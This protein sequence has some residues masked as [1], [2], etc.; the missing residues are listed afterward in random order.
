M[1]DFEQFRSPVEVWR[2]AIGDPSSL[3]DRLRGQTPMYEIERVAIAMLV[4][5]ELKRP[6]RRPSAQKLVSIW[7]FREMPASRRHLEGFFV[8]DDLGLRMQNAVDFYRHIM[9]ELR[10]DGKC[11]G[12]SDAV[13]EYV[14]DHDGLSSDSIRNAVRRV[15]KPKNTGDGDQATDLDV[16]CRNQFRI[17]C[18]SNWNE[19]QRFR[20]RKASH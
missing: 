18:E 9:A 6:K 1:M 10:K 16:Y 19:V 2:A 13:I 11:Y 3:A 7:S 5:G 12:V 20:G 15:R 14:A 8:P 4:D 17:W